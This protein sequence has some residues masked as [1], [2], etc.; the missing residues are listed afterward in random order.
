MS[1]ILIKYASRSRPERFFKG[2][3]SIYDNLADKENFNVLCSFDSDDISMSGLEIIN[4][5]NKYKNIIYYFGKSNSKIHAINRD[6]DKAPLFDILINFSDDQQFLINEFD[7]IIRNDMHAYF[8]LG[9]G[10]L[11]YPDSH[12]KE[13]L[14]TMSIMDKK[15][16][17]RT[18]YIYNPEYKNV[19]CDNEA[20]EVAKILGRYM[21]VNK[22]IFD[23]FHPIWG[24]AEM[25]AQYL[26]SE[27]QNSYRIDNN[28][29]QKRKAINFGL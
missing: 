15:Y 29:Y 26:I 12:T 11:H 20:M 25:D 10:F 4:R 21:F 16:F 22:I 9:D 6:M 23:H 19:Y 27:N 7:D 2:L 24:M 5:L 17:D 14:P 3:D 1:K 18:G 28:T 8:P 13:R